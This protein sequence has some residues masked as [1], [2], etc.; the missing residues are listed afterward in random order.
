M[1]VVT[2]RAGVLLSIGGLW[3]CGP[4]VEWESESSAETEALAQ[5]Q[6]AL[7]CASLGEGVELNGCPELCAL[8]NPLPRPQPRASLSRNILTTSLD[9]KL[10]TL[11]AT[12]AIQVAPS[13]ATGLSLKVGKIHIT[14]VRSRCGALNYTVQDGQLDIGMPVWASTVLVDYTFEETPDF[15]GYLPTGSTFLWPSFCANLFPC[16]PA[17]ADG[18]KFSLKVSNV[19]A[20]KKVV[21]PSRIPADA[22]AYMLA[23]AV[24]DY[25]EL[26][27]GHTTAGTQV[28]VWHLPGEAAV[29][30]TGT[31]HLK[32]AVD[33]FERQY[34]PYTF[35]GKVGSVSANWGPGA[36]GGMEHHPYWHVASDAMDDKLV[37]QHEA[38]HGWYG[39]GV[40]I[41][42]WE[43]FVLSEG[44][45]EYLTARSVR[46]TEGAE[47]EAAVWTQW[48]RELERAVSR[49]DTYALPDSTCNTI[50]I[51]THPLWSNIP[52]KKGAFFYKAL[53]KQIGTAAID[54]VLSRFYRRHVGGTARMQQFLDL[55]K[56]ETGQDP[57]P[58][59]NAWLRGLGIPEL[60]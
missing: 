24:G 13:L 34:G 51:L 38:A 20:G 46:A 50:D 27:L 59:A 6:E 31:L 9:V 30:T 22:P 21:Y 52:Y 19:P 14:G 1:N 43:D 57:T 29:A 32:D 41:R 23:W 54:R 37:H 25:T 5:T 3:A 7:T 56:A 39:N 44:T 2:R 45:A 49:G 58:L 48:T 10:D 8:V 53:E 4:T 28:S 35:G 33:F 26:P 11:S 16:H 47:A 18:V 40:R 17:L 55:V 42:C 60:P 15:D 12:A 36:Y